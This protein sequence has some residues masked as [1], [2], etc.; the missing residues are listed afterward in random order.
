MHIARGGGGGRQ[1]TA[2]HR[3]V[4]VVVLTIAQ[5]AV[6]L[7]AGAAAAACFIAI[8]GLHVFVQMVRSHE[9]FIT[10][11]TCKPFFAGVR[12]QVSLKL[13]RSG[14]AL[15]AEEPIADEGPLAGV[16]PQVRLQVRRLPV[17]LAAAGNVTAVDVLLQTG[18][19]RRAQPLRLLTVRTV[20]GGPAGVAT[21]RPRG[22]HRGAARAA[23][24]A[25]GRR[26]ER[27]GQTGCRLGEAAEGRGGA[28][29]TGAGQPHLRVRVL[30]E[31]VR[32]HARRGEQM[33]ARVAGRGRRQC[34]VGHRRRAV[35][36]LQ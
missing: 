11:G 16:P 32:L 1:L 30:Q 34:V 25:S 17:D 21:L 14:E 6:F 23:A 12:A 13:V 19:S 20:A 22:G 15:A 31:L 27:R 10:D 35:V 4:V 36:G 29:L 26:C 18:R 5:V 24:A 3:L 7:F 8:V 2:G 9:S 33:R 28:H